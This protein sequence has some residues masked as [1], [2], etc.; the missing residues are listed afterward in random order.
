MR[1]LRKVI[2]SLTAYVLLLNIFSTYLLLGLYTVK[3]DL[4]VELLCENKDR[5][6]LNCDGKCSL[7]K[8]IQQEKEKKTQSTVLNLMQFEWL[9]F[10]GFQFAFKAKTTIQ[11]QNPVFAFSNLYHFTFYQ[12]LVQPPSFS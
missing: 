12:D 7:G 9:T 10:S 5:P 2:L 1:N 3:K 11:Q 6:E 4:F 8:L